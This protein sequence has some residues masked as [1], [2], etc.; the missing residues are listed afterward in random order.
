MKFIKSP[1]HPPL[2]YYQLVIWRYL[3]TI[4]SYFFL[5]LFYSLVS[6]AFQIPFSTGTRS[7]VEVFNP[8]TAYGKGSFVV[9]W[10]LNF[11]GMGALGLA[12]ENTA[13]VL[14]QPW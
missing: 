8:A 4:V 12:C 3:A 9:Y 1:G 11:V 7:E 6:L 5:S 2:H 10:M 13:M 14:G